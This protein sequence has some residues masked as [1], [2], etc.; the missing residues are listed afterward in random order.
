MGPIFILKG[1]MKESHLEIRRL[2]VIDA[3]GAGA[4]SRVFIA[5]TTTLQ[6][7][8]W[9][10]LTHSPLSSCNGSTLPHL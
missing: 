4:V 1:P 2:L 7:V 3:I 5:G 8:L 9:Y 6:G 10:A